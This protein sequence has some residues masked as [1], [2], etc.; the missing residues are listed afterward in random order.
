[1]IPDVAHEVS[2]DQGFEMG[3]D[4]PDMGR[5]L[6]LDCGLDLFPWEQV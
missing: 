1:M 3:L 4:G 6:A 2:L 5:Y